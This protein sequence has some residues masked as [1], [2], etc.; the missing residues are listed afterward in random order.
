MMMIMMRTIVV[1]TRHQL[2]CLVL[3]LLLLQKM[4]KHLIKEDPSPTEGV[5]WEPREGKG[6][7]DVKKK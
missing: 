5:I 7:D 2:Y 4:A 1:R 6:S 3:L